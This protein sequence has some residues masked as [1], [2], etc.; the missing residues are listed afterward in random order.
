MRAN[1]SDARREAIG[2]LNR[3]KKFSPETIELMR[4]I[5]LS[6]PFMIAETRA[7]I[8]CKFSKKKIISIVS[9]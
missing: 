8:I 6:R 2:A 7:K 9:C 3:G 1:Y 5:A 4:Q